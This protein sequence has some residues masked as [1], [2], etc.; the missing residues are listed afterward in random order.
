MNADEKV[1]FQSD[2]PPR[3][4]PSGKSKV[5]KAGK[6][7]FVKGGRSGRRR[8]VQDDFNESL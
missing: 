6:D 2:P 4:V 1:E 5:Q 7:R 3:Y 8:V